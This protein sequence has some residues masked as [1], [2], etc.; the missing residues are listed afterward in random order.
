MHFP[1]LSSKGGAAYS[2]AMPRS[3]VSLYSHCTLC[4]RACGVDRTRGE[5]GFC[6]EG[7]VA[8]VSIACL[9]RGEEPP[10]SGEHGSGTVFFT[11]CTLGCPTCQNYMISG[12]A[13]GRRPG[14]EL[15]PQAL[16]N[17]FLALQDR[18]AHNINLVTGTQCIPSIIEALTMARAKGL[19]LP[20]VWNSS[21]Y[22]TEAALALLHPHIDIYLPDL[23]TLDP[24]TA[25]SLFGRPD[26]PNVVRPSLRAMVR[27]HALV[28]N[29]D[30][31]SRGVIVRHLVVPGRTAST[32]QCLEWFRDRLAGQALLSVMFQYIPLD[33]GA[34]ADGVKVD[35]VEYRQVTDTLEALDMEDGFI[36]ELEE[37][38]DWI[39]DFSRNNPFPP[40]FAEPVWRAGYGFIPKQ[41]KEKT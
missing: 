14:E 21:G 10:L 1:A 15:V 5:T 31:L 35:Q 12:G 33:R 38:D 37:A 19:S 32:R 29:G 2:S 3:P 23:K 22:E 27:D 39:P 8:R 40:G 30:L 41:E 6:G 17:L 4:P 9:H 7:T 28:W 24:A 16:A 20:V 26:Y 18:G 25:R 34:A 11:G 13:P 36:Q